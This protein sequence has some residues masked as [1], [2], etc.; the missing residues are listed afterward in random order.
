[1]LY[2]DPNSKD[3]RYLKNWGP[4]SL[5]NTDYKIFTQLLET[6]LQKVIPTV[7]SP[8]AT[9]YIKGRFIGKYIRKVLIIIQYVSEK[10]LSGILLQLYF[11]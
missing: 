11:E 3:L 8:Q 2:S 6:C 5:L 4:I 10:N 1:M 7:G 9:E